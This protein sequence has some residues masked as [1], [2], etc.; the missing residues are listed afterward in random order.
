MNGIARNQCEF[1]WNTTI[2]DNL[3]EQLTSIP[4]ICDRKSLAV[5]LNKQVESTLQIS[6]VLFGPYDLEKSAIE[7][8]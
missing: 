6:D 1:G 2:E 5:C 4:I 3:E 7:H 8:S